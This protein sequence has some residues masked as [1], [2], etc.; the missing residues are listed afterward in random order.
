MNIQG[1]RALAD[2]ANLVPSL[3]L[4]GTYSSET[5]ILKY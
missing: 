2:N 1:G 5:L 3:S 4:K